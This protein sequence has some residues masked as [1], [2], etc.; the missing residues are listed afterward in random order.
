MLPDV[1]RAVCQAALTYKE[2]IPLAKTLLSTNTGRLNQ[3]VTGIVSL[4]LS[5][6][7]WRDKQ[8]EDT[9]GEVFTFI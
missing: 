8:D 6:I 1:I 7:K 2:Q 5:T 9:E 4:E 3:D